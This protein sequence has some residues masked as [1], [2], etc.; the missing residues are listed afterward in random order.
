MIYVNGCSFT[1]GEELKEEN[2]H[3]EKFCWPGI[4]SKKINTIILNDAKSGSSNNRIIRTTTEWI[5]NNNPK[6]LIIIIGWSNPDRFEIMYKGKFK[7]IL[8]NSHETSTNDSIIK[9]KAKSFYKYIYDKKTTDI[10]FS[11]KLFLF[12]E[13]LKSRNIKYFFFNALSNNIE[14]DNIFMKNINLK[15]YLDFNKKNCD[16]FYRLRKFPKAPWD[17]PLEEGH[18]YWANVIYDEMKKVNLL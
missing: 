17:H 4:L 9:L 14:D 12:Q 13:F 3:R 10:E 8:H 11:Y 2:L 7:Q 5:L 1:Y 16:M 18:Y 6:K 15:F